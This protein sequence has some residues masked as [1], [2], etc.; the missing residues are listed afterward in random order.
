MGRAACGI[1]KKQLRYWA[2]PKLLV[3]D[4]LK[5]LD[6]G[7]RSA[8]PAD[9]D[10]LQAEVDHHHH[11]RWH[12]RLRDGVRRRRGGQR[13]CGLRLPPLPDHQDHRQVLPAEGS[14]AR[15]EGRGVVESGESPLAETAKERWR[16]R[17]QFVCIIGKRSIDD[18]T[19]AS[20]ELSR[21]AQFSWTTSSSARS[22]TV[23][24]T[25]TGSWSFAD[26]VTG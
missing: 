15:E 25:T 3:I 11:Q 26:T 21:W 1:F 2:H 17:H 10:A 7:S 19:T 5:F 20:V 8:L 16:D 18:I 22:S 24:S 9:F 23:L 4:E 6:L 14:A 13:R 12:R